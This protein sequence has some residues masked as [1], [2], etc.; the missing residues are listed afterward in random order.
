MLKRTR[1]RD[2]SAKVTFSLPA[3]DP[4]GPV[5]VVGDFNGWQPGL[6]QLTARSNG[7][8]SVAVEL[9]P[10][11]YK[12]RYL[13]TGGHWFDDEHADEIQSDGSLLMV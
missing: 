3:G 6:H 10:G 11:T 2:G 1:H 12:F 8:R 5:S 7:T 13:G 4:A 9:A